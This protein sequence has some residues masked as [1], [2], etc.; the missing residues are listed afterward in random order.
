[1]NLLLALLLLTPAH[2]GLFKKI[3]GK[4]IMTDPFQYETSDT[5]WL[6]REIERFEIKARWRALDAVDTETLQILKGELRRRQPA[7]YA[8]LD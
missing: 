7:W 6:V 4:L 5:E 2:A 8:P 3:C 1:M